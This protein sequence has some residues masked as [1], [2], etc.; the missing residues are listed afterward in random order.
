MIQL[1]IEVCFENHYG[2]IH[3]IFL[4]LG[5]TKS[6]YFFGMPGIYH[7][8]TLISETIVPSRGSFKR[9]FCQSASYSLAH[10]TPKEH[11]LLTKTVTFN[12]IEL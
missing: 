10:G 11:D 12:P 5:S 1:A 3:V 9:P 7:F 4:S 2:F 8:L 6:V